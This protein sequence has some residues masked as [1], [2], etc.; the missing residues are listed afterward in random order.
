MKKRDYAGDL[1]ALG[2][3]KFSYL[4]EKKSPDPKE[5]L[6]DALDERDLDSRIVEGLPWLAVTYVDMDWDWLVQNASLHR[7]Q[8][9][10]GFVVA[11]AIDLA[12]PKSDNERLLKLRQQLEKLE[13]IRLAEEDTLCHDSMTTTERAWLRAHRSPTAA[14]WNILSDLTGREP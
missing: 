4:K 2:Y 9:R 13:T 3:P 5:L 11:L 7:R 8:N 1:R 10:L 12:R 14:H 6:F